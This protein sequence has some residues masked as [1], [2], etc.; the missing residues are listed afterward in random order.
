MDEEKQIKLQFLDEAE[1][2]LKLIESGLIGIGKGK[3]SNQ[4]LD[5]ILRAAHSLKGG[6]AMMG[7]PILSEVA[8]RLEDFWKIIKAGK[9]TP[10]DAEVEDLFFASVD[11][12][13]HLTSLHRQQKGIESTWFETNLQPLL[14][15]LHSHLGDLAPEDAAQIMAED[16]GEN[17]L[18]LLFETEVEEC[19]QRL[20]V[21][22]N[23]P[24]RSHLQA[25]FSLAAEEL[26]GLAEMLE[27]PALVSFCNSMRAEIESGAEEKGAIAT[28]A[29]QEL[30]RIQ[31]MV[32]VEQLETIPSQF[33]WDALSAPQTQIPTTPVEVETKT[34]KK[35]PVPVASSGF[36]EFDREETF[37][38]RVRVSVKHLEEMG[39]LF[40]EL[41][42]G[43]N[44]I[45]MQLKQMRQS[46]HLLKQR[47]K[48]LEQ[49]NQ[50]LRQAY[51]RVELQ[52]N[53]LRPRLM[54]VGSL[55]SE[56]QL[57]TNQPSWNLSHDGS[58]SNFDLLEMDRYSNFHLVSQEIMETVVQIEEVAS[59]I[60][61][62][63]R[64][65]EGKAREIN[66][67]TKL[68]ETQISKV[69]MSPISKVLER[70]PR[71]LRD[72]IRKYN[73]QVELK[74][75]GG[76]TLVERPILEALRE[77]LLHIF[78]NAF[79]HG[80]EAPEIRKKLGKPETG[81]IEITAAYRGNQTVITIKDDGRGI[82]FQKIRSQALKMGIDSQELTQA[83]QQDLL[84]LIFAP[85]F[86]TA[87]QVTQLS[88][89]GVGMDVVRTNLR[90]VRGDI[91]I[92]T[93]VGVGTTFTITVPFNL[94][95]M[96][97]FVV[98][99][100]RMLLAFP[101]N[102]VEEVNVLKPAM[103]TETKGQKFLNWR[104]S[105]IPLFSLQK[106]LTFNC[107]RSIMSTE[108]DPAIDG[109]T[110][111]VIE[112]EEN[113]VA[114]EVERYWGEQEVTIRQVE[115]NLTMPLGFS[116]CTILGN[117]RVVPLVEPISLI[118][119]LQHPQT[120]TSKSFASALHQSQKKAATP[121]I[122]TIMIVDDS[123][124]VRRFLGLTLEKAG[125]RVEQAKD[126]KEALE[127][128]KLGIQVQT[129]ICDLEMPRM[130]GYSL[131]TYLKSHTQYK[132]IPI[133]MLTSRAGS[134][135][136]QLALNLGAD[137]YFVKPFQEK[138]LL[139]AI[140]DKLTYTTWQN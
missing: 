17:M 30:R 96:R 80:I 102:A 40:G 67:A 16:T 124:N 7:Y 9:I 34:V 20:E 133:I 33:N 83:T 120:E 93:K 109:S 28:V 122:Q 38:S 138:E 15:K 36:D 54:T 24:D 10:V 107:P 84:E 69:R 39:H 18:N 132:K 126:G 128:L 46:V 12:L 59:D 97:V 114:V 43:R 65:T 115:G 68:M 100:N 81:A 51:D 125:W 35:V 137:G 112:Q 105:R 5:A 95:V 119:W 101:T 63:L 62:N 103:L 64:E 79:D 3:V 22:I 58:D 92:D 61:V 90:Q 37:G 110:V 45:E 76:S 66:R 139:A 50:T 127:K 1:D 86:S 32:L 77:P 11:R 71:A 117:G 47:I 78:R 89:R 8:H 49:S 99:S 26:G 21:A 73:K 123:I 53:A 104:E 42:I 41:A 136:R 135:H 57:A 113:S 70:F 130:D 131:L 27:L 14:D 91:H 85:G 4:S 88:G 23:Q 108:M 2:Y 106:W 140:R 60:E 29:L 111:L 6:A 52:E 82:D 55:S 75:R 129:I 25:E 118:A 116:A 87:N 31:A 74:I 121:K 56:R 94:S 134:K 44:G 48:K 72:L 19:L 98:E 13:H